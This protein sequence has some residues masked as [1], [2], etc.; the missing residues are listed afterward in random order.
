ML[1][2]NITVCHCYITALVYAD[3]ISLSLYLSLY[4]YLSLSLSQSLSLNLSLSRAMS[5]FL[6]MYSYLYISYSVTR[7]CVC[8]VSEPDWLVF[9]LQEVLDVPHLVV[10]RKQPFLSHFRALFDSETRV[11]ENWILKRR[12]HIVHYHH[13][14]YHYNSLLASCSL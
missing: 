4:T 10:R 1:N 7:T 8:S 12:L 3:I 5:I 11:T 14:Q 9:V 13:N 2:N 6:C